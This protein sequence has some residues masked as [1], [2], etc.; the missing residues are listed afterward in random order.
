ME[1]ESKPVGVTPIMLT[2]PNGDQCFVLRP[3]LII[4]VCP[5][6]DARLPML[7][8]MFAA[9]P[10]FGIAD[11]VANRQALGV[12]TVHGYQALPGGSH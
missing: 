7:V 1:Q 10:G 11:T 3:D 12:P 2:A 4:A 5:A 6:V 8:L 9:M